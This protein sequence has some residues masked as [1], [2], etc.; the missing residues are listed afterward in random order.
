MAEP[1]I[2]FKETFNALPGNF[3][4][5]KPDAPVYTILAVSNEQ[6]QIT[7]TER[8]EIVGKSVFEVYPA[9]GE[10]HTGSGPIALRNSLQH[11]LKYM[12]KDSMPM[13][14]YDVQNESGIFEQRYWSVNNKPVLD[15]EGQ[16]AYLIH[17]AIDITDKVKSL[18]EELQSVREKIED[19]R[20]LLQNLFNQA[21]V[22]L[23][24]FTGQELEVVTANQLLCNMWGHTPE[25]VLNRPLLEGVPELQGQ[26]FDEL[27][28]QVLH[29]GEPFIGKEVAA[30][31]VRNGTLET[32]YYNFVYQPLYDEQRNIL[33]VVDVAIEVTELVQARKKVEKREKA[34]Q[35][36]NQ[37]LENRVRE[38]TQQLEIAHQQAELQWKELFNLFEQAPVA[39]AVI[40]GP[41]YV[42]DLANHKVCALWGRTQQQAL[43]IPLFE[44]LPEAAGQGFEELLDQVMATGEPYLA[45]ELPSQINRNGRQDTVY[46][47]FVYY[48]FRDDQQE[49]KGVTVVANEVTEQ[50]LARKKI[51]ES[52]KELRRFKFMAD[53]AQDAFVLIRK[54]WTFAYLNKNA[55]ES[56]GYSEEEARHLRLADIEPTFQEEQFAQIFEKA[57][58]ES[59]PPAETWHKRK[60]GELFPVDVNAVGLELDGEPYVF[61]I[62]RDISERKKVEET[63]RLK[64][65]ELVH[66]N[67]DLDNFIYTASHDLRT[68]ITNIEGLI[69]ILL[70]NL[71]TETLKVKLVQQIIDLMQESVT[72][73][74]KTIAV[75]S[76]V[77]KLQK[78]YE[79]DVV[80]VDLEAVMQ[81][82][83]LDLQPMIREFGAELEID[84]TDC[85]F[86]RFSEKNLRSVIYNLLSNA[87][88]YHSPER[89]PKIHIRCE[90]SGEYKILTV[91][92]NGIGM[93]KNG[94]DQ[95]FNMF[96]RFHTQVEGTGIGLYMVKKLVVNAGGHIKV[97]SQEGE[98]TTFRV[99]FPS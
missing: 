81:E 3:L 83:Q 42:I 29:T 66:I 1:E 15:R 22:A 86:I 54:D 78:E 31:L 14:R 53:Q 70:E 63:L 94:L 41:D 26:E 19:E 56:W 9:K 72:R 6:L 8:K 96:K 99:Y 25:E 73:F 52:Q 21:P 2:D 97:E 87:I 80:L 60:G 34:L 32:T 76:D 92:D 18:T 88:K 30:Q 40:K 69:M 36:L 98:G 45:K 90:S 47:N 74:K 61:A 24:L 5:L 33:G 68:P 55:L 4:I 85:P 95:I 89:L 7:G 48:P 35:D 91:K 84:L 13:V 43:N 16:V 79:G 50:V 57:Q 23:G 46:W 75:L 11:V 38:R 12:T 51:V 58:K 77:V 65:K 59:I 62:A 37:Q 49:I 64:N 82:V 39:I 44:L 17:S 20:N 28:R 71:P 67:N 93:R 10:T 27:I